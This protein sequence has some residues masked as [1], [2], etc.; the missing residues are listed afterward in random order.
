[1]GSGD[2]I[3][4]VPSETAKMQEADT[5]SQ[6]T[7]GIIPSSADLGIE[8]TNITTAAGVRLSSEQKIIVGSILDVR[9]LQ[10]RFRGGG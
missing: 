1:M 5:G 8:N 9:F 7:G 3:S 6:Q 10:R 2:G 4:G